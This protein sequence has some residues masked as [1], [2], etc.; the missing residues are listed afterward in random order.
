MNVPVNVAITL[1]VIVPKPL[2]NTD[3]NYLQKHQSKPV[4]S[5][6]ECV[7]VCALVGNDGVMTLSRRNKMGL[8]SNSKKRCDVG[9]HY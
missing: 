9:W 6:Q 7:E 5:A 8:S 4:A 3:T 2:E 1:I